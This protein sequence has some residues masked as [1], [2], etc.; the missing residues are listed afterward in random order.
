MA[1]D[2]VRVILGYAP[3]EN[4]KTETREEFFTELEMEIAKSKMADELPLVV[5]DMNAKISMNNNT[6][7]NPLQLMESFLSNSSKIKSWTF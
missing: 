4:D 2:T 5:G 3:Q 6:P 1:T 7:L